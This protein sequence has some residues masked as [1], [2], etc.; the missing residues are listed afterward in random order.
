[1][2]FCVAPSAVRRAEQPGARSQLE[3]GT[4]SCTCT[5][6]S[7]R[8]ELFCLVH[9]FRMHRPR[10]NVPLMCIRRVTTALKL[11]GGLKTPTISSARISDQVGLHGESRLHP[12]SSS[13]L[14]SVAEE[15]W[16]VLQSPKQ[17][18]A[19][20]R[21]LII[22]CATQTERCPAAPH[23]QILDSPD[24]QAPRS[25]SCALA[26]VP[27]RLFAFRVDAGA[28]GG[29]GRGFAVEERR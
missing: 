3:T 28:R 12:S 25:Q 15:D 20:P 27:G 14:L 1:V 22:S 5:M 7:I 17:C 18:A 13:L 10:G 6:R 16:P 21:G 29:R 2:M 19:S 8:N 4:S 9:G 23:F 11:P 26:C 24:S